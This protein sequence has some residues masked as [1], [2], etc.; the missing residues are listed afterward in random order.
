[1]VPELRRAFNRDFTEAKYCRLQQRLVEACRSPVDFRISETP[2]F[3]TPEMFRRFSSAG[4]EMVQQLVGD[5]DYRRASNQTVPDEWNV[6]GEDEHP[7]F[8]QVDFGLV[9]RAQGGLEPRLVELQA[10]PS[11]YA[12]QPVLARLFREAY[13]LPSELGVFPEG[14]TAESYAALLRRAIVG[15]CNAENVVLLEIDPWN[16]KTRCDFALTAE[17]LGIAVVDVRSVVKQQ[18]RLYYRSN[19]RLVPIERIYNRAIV[20]ELV[21]RKVAL[22]FDYRDELQVTWAGH[23][24]WY[25]RISKFSLPYLRH[26]YVPRTW[27]LDDLEHLPV[28]RENYVLKPLYSFAGAGIVF[29]PSDAQIAA[30]EPCQRHNFILQE[31]VS[32]ARTVETPFGDTQAEFRIMYIWLEQLMPVMT[33]V[34][35]GR[36]KMMGVDHNKD[37][38]WVGSSACLMA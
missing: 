30:I 15:Q 37:L 29:A 10:F 14:L 28:H 25:F 9:R 31:R 6:A 33:L 7:L 22:P 21:R 3:I 5:P 35:M 24:N 11:L 18:S 38:R 27:F 36:G 4:A 20:D 19:G 23:P 17:M 32:F 26:A 2:C 16:Q 34:R 12:Y 8:V 13:E 1:M